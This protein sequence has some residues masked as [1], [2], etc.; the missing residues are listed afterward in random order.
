MKNMR[1]Y[2]DFAQALLPDGI[3]DYYY[4]TDFKKKETSLCIYLEEKPDIPSEYK[5]QSYRLSGFMP[6]VTIKDFPIR[7][8]KA[9]LKIK[10]CR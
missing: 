9:E 8:Y 7:E 4:L 2:K 10:R 5:D 1:I 3:L 6:E